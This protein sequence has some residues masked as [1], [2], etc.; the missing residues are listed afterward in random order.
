VCVLVVYRVIVIVG[1]QGGFGYTVKL[2]LGDE[3]LAASARGMTLIA[4]M[5]DWDGRSVSDQRALIVASSRGKVV[6]S[7]VGT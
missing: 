5:F 3:E 4:L 2:Q 6:V 7:E 1:G